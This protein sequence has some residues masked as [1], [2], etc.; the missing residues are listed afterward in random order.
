MKKIIYLSVLLLISTFAFSQRWKTERSTIVFG[1]GTSNFMG[2]LGGG[3][4]DAAHFLGARDIDPSTTRPTVQLSYKYRAT[5]AISLK[6]GVTYA[7]LSGKD[8]TSQSDGRY[9]RNLSFR[10]NTWELYGQFEYAVLVEKESPRYSFSS[11]RSIR[12]LSV[13][14]FG[15]LGVFYYNPKTKYDGKWIALRPLRTEGQGVVLSDGVDFYFG[16]DGV[17]RTLPQEYKSYAF[18]IPLGIGFKYNLTREWAVGLEIS[19]RYTTTD[20]LDDASGFYFN[21]AEMA[22][23]KMIASDYDPILDD[24]TDKHLNEDGTPAP[25]YKTGQPYRGS[26][27]YKDAYILTVITLHYKIK[28]KMRGQPKF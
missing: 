6:T 23:K 25:K 26:P 28:F 8:N 17:E 15:G 14:L 12:N 5:Q 13:Y 3:A 10:T 27:S 16:K 21:Y 18:T 7:L 24:I 2:D 11:L 19:N 9:N 1:L 4:K 20:Y 22:G